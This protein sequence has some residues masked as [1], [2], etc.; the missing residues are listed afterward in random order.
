MTCKKFCTA[1]IFAPKIGCS[2]LWAAEKTGRRTGPY[3][4]VSRPPALLRRPVFDGRDKVGIRFAQ[5]RWRKL[6][7][8][9]KEEVYAQTLV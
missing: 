2:F 1:K 4:G 9:G 3:P 6:A 7:A 8:G 5:F